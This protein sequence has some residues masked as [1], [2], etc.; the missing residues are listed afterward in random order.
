MT[1]PPTSFVPIGTPSR[2]SISFER[3]VLVIV[4]SDSVLNR[5]DELCQL[6]FSDIRIQVVFTVPEPRSVVD[7][8]IDAEIRRRGGIFVPWEI[9]LKLTF[10][11]AIVASPN[12]EFERIDAPLLVLQHGPGLSKPDA[13]KDTVAM[14]ER[15]EGR[16]QPTVILEPTDSCEL[17]TVPRG[18]RVEEVGDPV[19]DSLLASAPLRQRYREA[20]G[21]GNRRLI[22]VS[23]TWGPAG[24]VATHPA[25]VGRLLRELP[26]NEFAIAL[27]LHPYI[28][29]A[30]GVWQIRTW[31]RRELAAGLMLIPHQSSWQATILSADR[32]VGDHGSVTQYAV[33]CGIPT[34][35]ST[36]DR[37]TVEA[38]TPI[39]RESK[40]SAVTLISDGDALDF[41]HKSIAGE[42]SPCA[43]VS[44]SFSHPG[45]S[46]R[47]IRSV[48]YELLD[49]TPPGNDLYSP[50]L[51][52][53]V[54]I[55][56]DMFAYR[57][58]TTA[59]VYDESLMM[60]IGV[61]P[62]SMPHDDIM[63]DGPTIAIVGM[64]PG[65]VTLKANILVDISPRS[66]VNA[67]EA[68]TRL[69]CTF[70]KKK[71]VLARVSDGWMVRQD[72]AV[73]HCVTTIASPS[74]V[75]AAV[76]YML[77]KRYVEARVN[78]C[79]ATHWVRLRNTGS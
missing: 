78:L 23:S 40:G 71:L 54:P 75:A 28:W 57:T 65:L 22:V 73:W 20:L 62:L 35:R 41:C 42:I 38:N 5:L 25:L 29:K 24:L 9:A 8:G 2:N 72:N 34:I 31:L 26:S 14:L 16:P 58:S 33:V 13:R 3:V 68:L 60:R 63:F 10:D 59:C 1:P 17:G 67:R 56:E 21:A 44:P 53:P 11:L 50:E 52:R 4:R 47:H 49:L 12:G 27:I 46:I 39:A 55:T 69:Y 48:A 15:L 79:G 19:Y 74:T 51:P 70:G 64:S 30:H 32:M 76:I 37:L 36:S 77:R 18:I 43:R 6:V 7:R 45:D 66:E 61:Y